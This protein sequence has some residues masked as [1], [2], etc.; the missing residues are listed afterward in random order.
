MKKE[1]KIILVSCL[2]VIVNFSIRSGTT[3]HGESF[4]GQTFKAGSFSY[5]VISKN[6]VLVYK[7]DHQ[8]P[9]TMEVVSSVEYQGKKYNVTKFHYDHSDAITKKII[10]PSV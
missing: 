8:E 6:E 7:Y 5:E 1:V 4:I 9:D 10:I 2:F 3:I